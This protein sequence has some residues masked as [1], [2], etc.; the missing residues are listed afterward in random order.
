MIKKM[1][2]KEGEVCRVYDDT[3]FFFSIKSIGGPRFFSRVVKFGIFAYDI[4]KN[5]IKIFF[6]YFK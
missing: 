4:F 6:K 1:E 3:S 5:L 2:G